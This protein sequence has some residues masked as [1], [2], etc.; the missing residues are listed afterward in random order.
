[1]GDNHIHTNVSHDG[2]STYMEYIDKALT[3][4]LKHLTFTEHWDSY[5]GVNS[6]IKT[7]D[8][9]TYRKAFLEGTKDP[10]GLD[11]GYGIEIGL[12]PQVECVY[13][14]KKIVYENDF[15]FIIGS[16][17]ITSGKDMSMDPSFFDGLTKEEAITKYLEQV[18][19]SIRIYP[20]SFD[21]YG[22][23][24]Y[25]VR[26]IIKNYGLDKSYKIIYKV[27]GDILDT[28][29]LEIIN[30]DKGIELNTSGFRYGLGS[31][32]PNIEILKRYKELGGR[33]ITLGSDAHKVE[34][35][36][37]NFDVAKNILLDVGFDEVAVYRKR[38]PTFY[39]IK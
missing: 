4:C 6:N 13:Q 2:I 36:A 35:L 26:Y 14:T 20:N 19:L 16:M 22:H 32:H 29:L 27:F 38:K 5:A 11:I 37:S 15:D 23:I 1:M 12:R 24:D 18:L 28:I 17:H 21:V 30:G 31:P 34:D 3:L 10:K 8:I 7:L 33:I 9:D 39:S 25:V